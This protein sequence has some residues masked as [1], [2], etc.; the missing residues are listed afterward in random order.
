MVGI[1]IQGLCSIIW[2]LHMLLFIYLLNTLNQHI[3]LI[4]FVTQTVC[5]VQ[6]LFASGITENVCLKMK[7]HLIFL[8]GLDFST[9][10]KNKTF[11]TRFYEYI[12]F[13]NENFL[14]NLKF[15]SEYE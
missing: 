6:R 13:S 8:L 15:G 10:H 1:A 5:T 11:F 7:L 12:L 14:Q 4:H 2:F 3:F 9:L